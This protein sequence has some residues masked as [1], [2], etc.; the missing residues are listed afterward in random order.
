MRYLIGAL[1]ALL[2]LPAAAQAQT[3]PKTPIGQ[4][5]LRKHAYDYGQRQCDKKESYIENG[6]PRVSCDTV[7]TADCR[8]DA[9]FPTA[10]GSC[11]LFFRLIK[12]GYGGLPDKY[13]TWDA[14]VFWRRVYDYEA[15]RWRLRRQE[16][17]TWTHTGWRRLEA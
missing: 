5:T 10:L 7:W 6:L 13:Q 8:A 14:T 1:V 15:G 16:P 3:P 2:L 9:T 17:T 4:K 11:E 12:H